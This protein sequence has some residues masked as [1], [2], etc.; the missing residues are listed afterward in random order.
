[1]K[2]VNDLPRDKL[3]FVGELHRNH[4][5]LN[6]VAVRHADLAQI[7]TTAVGRPVVGFAAAVMY[8]AQGNIHIKIGKPIFIRGGCTQQRIGGCQQSAGDTVN[9]VCGVQF[10]D[11][12]CDH[13][14]ICRDVG[15]VAAAIQEVGAGLAAVCIGCFISQIAGV[16]VQLI[17]ANTDFAL[18]NDRQ[19]AGILKDE[20]LLFNLLSADVAYIYNRVIVHN[21]T[22]LRVVD[23]GFGKHQVVVLVIPVEHH[24]VGVVGVDKA[25]RGLH[26]GNCIGT[27]RQRDGDFALRAI[28]GHFQEI[29]GGRCPCGTEPDFVHLPV[30]G[31]G[32]GGDK[33]AV[34][35]PECAL[36]VRRGNVALRV[37][38]IGGIGSRP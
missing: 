23:D 9:I 32:N 18:L 33:V 10:I 31:S 28:V 14:G 3:V 37:D 15:A 6:Q 34:C 24:R 13:L 12:P 30:F 35:V 20:N 29:I 2:A 8:A 16:A 38:L 17:Q 19:H 4:A 5:L 25:V 7:V 22:V 26:F 1:M 36:I 21:I 11:C 27:Q